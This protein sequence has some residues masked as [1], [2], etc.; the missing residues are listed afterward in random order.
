MGVNLGPAFL[1]TR[2]LAVVPE[3]RKF[4]RDDRSINVGFWKKGLNA[5]Y[6]QSIQLSISIK[7]SCDEK[8]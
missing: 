7:S 1:C 6:T 5:V 3:V 4:R 2:P 8:S